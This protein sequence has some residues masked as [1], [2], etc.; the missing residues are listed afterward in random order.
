MY[1]CYAEYKAA[2]SPLTVSDYYAPGSGEKCRVSVQCSGKVTLLR[3]G[4]C[5]GQGRAWLLVEVAE[6]VPNRTS[7]T[8]LMYRLLNSTA[9]HAM[10]G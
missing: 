5:A 1:L 6:A 10:C 2:F 9:D 4:A 3:E 8:Y 7:C